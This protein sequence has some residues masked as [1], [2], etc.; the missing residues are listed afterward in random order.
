MNTKVSKS[1]DTM[2]GGLTFGNNNKLTLGNFNALQ[3]YATGTNSLIFNNIGDLYFYN[4][5][6]DRSIIFRTD[7]G[8]GGTANYIIANGAT[9]SV[10]L[11]HYGTEKFKTTSGGG[12]LTGNLLLSAAP[13]ANDHAVRKDYVDNAVS[14]VN[15]TI[16][17]LDT[18][19]IPEGINNLYYTNARVDARILTNVS[20]FTNDAGYLTSETDSQ[21]LTFSSP[22]LTISNGNVVDLSGLVP[23]NISSFTNDI[24][25]YELSEV[26]TL[27]V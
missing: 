1:G 20:A 13:T 25:Y 18:D 4:N 12:E 2:T 5:V 15:T 11:T 27:I 14:G 16:G 24:G 17:D 8:S 22:N 23:T 26:D 19:D 21:T 9:G 6:D 7:N 3:M 10:E